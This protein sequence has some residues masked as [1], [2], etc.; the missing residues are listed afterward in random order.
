MAFCK[1]APFFNQIPFQHDQHF[2][3]LGDLHY[4]GIR[5]HDFAGIGG[6]ERG[7]HNA[8]R[9]WNENGSAVGQLWILSIGFD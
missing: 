1:Y 7:V 8:A 9:N 2:S 3:P 6:A 4:F 5:V